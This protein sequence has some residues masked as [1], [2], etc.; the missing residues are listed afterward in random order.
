MRPPHRIFTVLPAIFLFSA[1]SITFAAPQGQVPPQAKS[2]GSIEWADKLRELVDKVVVVSVPPARI[3]LSMS[4]MSSLTADEVA[5]IDDWLKA[6]LMNRRLRLVTADPV[7]AHVHVTLS[8]GV[9][10]YLIVAEIRRGAAEQV[11]VFPVSKG[12]PSAKRAGGVRLDQNLVWEQPGKILDFAL[13][14]PSAGG[15]P[16]MIVLEAERIM[17][18]VRR[19]SQWQLSESITIPPLRP[20]LRALRGH[21]DFSRGL[22]AG[23]AR[24]PGIDCK[25]DFERP[26]TIQCGFVDQDTQSWSAG[27]ASAPK[28]PDL[29]G[30]TVNVSLE[31][32]GR[33]V[34]LASGKGDWTETDFIQGYEIGSVEGQEAMASEKPA[35]FEGPVTSLWWTG[36]GGVASAVVQN[37]K[38][39]NYEAYL[40]T[41]TCSH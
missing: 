4:N 27:N 10:G 16:T 35:E 25:G 40:V 17:F 23:V 41:A 18:Y 14:P 15:N 32:D 13:P 19:E 1:F 6:N 24:L 20:W 34:L 5:A 29:G 39:G 9:A 33:P 31:C 7:D 11:L 22:G 36:T 28:I 26:D 2:L 38:T 21:I 37:L 8:E 3:E 30:D 12:A